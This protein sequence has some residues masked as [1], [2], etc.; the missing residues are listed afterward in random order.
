[1]SYKSYHAAKFNNQDFCIC[2]LL[3]NLNKNTKQEQEQ[4]LRIWVTNYVTLGCYEHIVR[5]DS[6][7]IFTKKYSWSPVNS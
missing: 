4:V 7:N 2:N 3:F 6:R 1:M 5:I